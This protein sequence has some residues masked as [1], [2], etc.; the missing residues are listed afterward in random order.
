MCEN[1]SYFRKKISYFNKKKKDGNRQHGEIHIVSEEVLTCRDYF[2]FKIKF[3]NLK[4]IGFFNPDPKT[5]ME[6]RKT[7][8]SGDDIL[9][10]RSNQLRGR[11]PE[12]LTKISGQKLCNGD[13]GRTIKIQ[14]YRYRTSKMTSDF[15]GEMSLTPNELKSTQISRSIG[16]VR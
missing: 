11:Q 15:W 9:V 7:S 3:T 10:E 16:E 4:K 14:L 2:S 6:I 1:R 5:Y 8:E 12:F 13:L